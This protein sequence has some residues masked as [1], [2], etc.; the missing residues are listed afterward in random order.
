MKWFRLYAEIIDDM[1]IV[2][3]PDDEFRV[4]IFL[5]GMAAEE[6][7]EGIL[8]GTLDQISWRLRLP[9]ELIKRSIARMKELNILAQVENGLQFIN[10]KKRQFRSDDVSE[11]VRKFRKKGKAE[12]DKGETLHETL[13]ETL[14]ETD[15]SRAETEQSRETTLVPHDEIVNLYHKILPELPGVKSWTEKRQKLLRCRWKEDPKRQT[16]EWW[17]KYFKYVRESSF[18]MGNGG[19]G[20]QPNLEWLIEKSNLV[21]TIEGKYHNG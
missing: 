20:W 10:W 11:R 16:T 9:T 18:L 8:T 21:N 12:G 19:K 3:F 7:K 17:E 6:E 15:Q 13:P 14:D 4:F 1:K 2:K 5:L